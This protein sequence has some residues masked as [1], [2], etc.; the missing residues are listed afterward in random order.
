MALTTIELIIG[1]AVIL[2]SALGLW[3]NLNNEHT[4]LKARVYQL[5]RSDSDLKTFLAD[6]SARLHAIELLLASNQ[7]K[8]K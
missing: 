1:I 3:V 6:I 4:K 5:E 2:A 8:E 7:I